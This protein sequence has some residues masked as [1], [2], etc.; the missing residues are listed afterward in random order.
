MR[1]T[2]IITFVSDRI[3]GQGDNGFL[4]WARPTHSDPFQALKRATIDWQSHKWSLWEI[5]ADADVDEIVSRL[6][7]ECVTKYGFP[8]R[9]KTLQPA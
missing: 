3:I 8:C 2:D 7:E 5:G 9:P 6:K 4:Y 1:I